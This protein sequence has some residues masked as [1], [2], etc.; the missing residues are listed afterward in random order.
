MRSEDGQLDADWGAFDPVFRALCLAMEPTHAFA[1]L[2]VDD[3][4]RPKPAS[5]AELRWETLA[6]DEWPAILPARAYFGAALRAIAPP[7]LTALAAPL[8]SGLCVSDVTG[9]HAG[10]L[11][12]AFGDRMRPIG[13]RLA[14]LRR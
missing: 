1:L 4:S 5:P 6:P 14:V 10:A 2:F 11:A 3:D 12:T 7:A 13:A 9:E 8:G